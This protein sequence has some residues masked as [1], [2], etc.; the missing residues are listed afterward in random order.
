MNF[1]SGGGG[2]LEGDNSGEDK[3]ATGWNLRPEEIEDS[4]RTVEDAQKHNEPNRKLNAVR[5]LNI[6]LQ[7]MHHQES[8]IY[9]NSPCII[10]R[11][12]KSEFDQNCSKWYVQTQIYAP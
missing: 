1:S 5:K 4:S 9:V 10:Y 11:S 12:R 7:N 6:R 8:N 3:V 2:E